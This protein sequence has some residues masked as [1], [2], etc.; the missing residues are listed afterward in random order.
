MV[1][2]FWK[3]S[4]GSLSVDAFVARYGF[5]G[6]EEGEVSSTSWREDPSLVT[7]IAERYA[8]HGVEDRAT[9]QD[10]RRERRIAAER[11]LLAN[12][13][14][15]QRVKARGVLRLAQRYLPLREVGKAAFLMALDVAR[16]AAR[17]HGAE[18]VAK[19]VLAQAD[20][21][22]A[23]TVPE[24]LRGLDDGRDEV[25][26]VAARRLAQRA[27]YQTLTFPDRWVGMPQP[28]TRREKRADLRAGDTIAGVS[29]THGVVEGAARVATS[30]EVAED[31]EPG[32]SWFA[33]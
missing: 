18:L 5:H 9:E 13:P 25:R 11:T 19:G 31:L 17:R 1:A 26:D 28:R 29:I 7:S 2:A 32:R 14:T 16:F 22:F 3:V 33:R 20:D 30:L 6:P 8:H 15:H 4:R 12:L 27:E 24:V 21:V 23:F 10:D